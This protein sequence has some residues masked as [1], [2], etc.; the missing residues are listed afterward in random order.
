MAVFSIRFDEC[1]S[2]CLRTPLV[3]AVGTED[4][5]EEHFDQTVGNLL[6]Q[7]FILNRCLQ[8]LPTLF[9]FEGSQHHDA[10]AKS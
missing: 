3:N 6:E 7:I 1:L 8:Q 4:A 9:R 5:G 10:S 2:L